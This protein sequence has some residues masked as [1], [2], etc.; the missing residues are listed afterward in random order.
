MGVTVRQELRGGDWWI[1]IHHNG[2]RESKAIGKDKGFAM[3]MAEKIKARL[4]LGDF[5]MDDPKVP[6]FK[7]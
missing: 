7:E 2:R 3:Q 5:R 6:T 4:V 1:F